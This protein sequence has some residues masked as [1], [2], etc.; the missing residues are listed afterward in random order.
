MKYEK[1]YLIVPVNIRRNTNLKPRHK[2][3]LS[4]II[5]LN[6][7]RFGCIAPDETLAKMLGVS[8]PTIKRW[9]GELRKLGFVA[10][11]ANGVLEL[12]KHFQTCVGIIEKNDTP[13]YQKCSKSGIRIDT[14][15]R[16]YNTSK[17]KI[18]FGVSDE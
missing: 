12:T 4:E 16:K 7:G 8:H 11:R 6:N 5:A 10:F 9:L 14:H 18:S 13:G 17:R 3:L 2:I 1:G 15:K